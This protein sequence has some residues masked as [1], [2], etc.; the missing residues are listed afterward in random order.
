MK[1]AVCRIHWVTRGL[2]TNMARR[3]VRRA[4]N[5]RRRS[6]ETRYAVNSSAAPQKLFRTLTSVRNGAEKERKRE[7]EREREMEMEIRSLS[8][9]PCL[10]Q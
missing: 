2:A 5:S 3:N 4:T 6:L 9:S 10:A 1:V 7:R 8:T